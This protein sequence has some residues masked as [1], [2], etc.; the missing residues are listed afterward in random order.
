M[1]TKE[2]SW[3]LHLAPLNKYSVTGTSGTYQAA[4][5]DIGKLHV[6]VSLGAITVERGNG[7]SVTATS[8]NQWPGSVPLY[9]RPVKNQD[10]IGWAGSS[11]TVTVGI[12]E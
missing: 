11:T 3:F 7:S 9:F 1:D 5:A 4:S 2:N 12:L 6:L 8:K 10:A